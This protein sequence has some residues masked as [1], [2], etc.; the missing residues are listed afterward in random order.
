MVEVVPMLD[1]ANPVVLASI[2]VPAYYLHSAF[3]H[4]VAN[5]VM[6]VKDRSFLLADPTCYFSPKGYRFAN[7]GR[8]QEIILIH[9]RSI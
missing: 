7:T 6:I 9:R 3:N 4:C 1:I 8:H 5:R 2:A